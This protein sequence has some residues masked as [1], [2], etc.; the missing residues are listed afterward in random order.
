MVGILEDG[1]HRVLAAPNGRAAQRRAAAYP[2]EIDVLVTDVITP[3]MNG[4]ELSDALQR[5]RPG[6]RTLFVSGYAADHLSRAGAEGV[7]FLQ[8]P[9]DREELLGR[10]AEVLAREPP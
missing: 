10:V 6:I 1:G 7:A 9:F 8:K 4:R 5:Q 2:G 3:G